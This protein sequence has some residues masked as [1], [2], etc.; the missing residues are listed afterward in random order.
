MD[1]DK[2]FLCEVRVE[3]LYTRRCFAVLNLVWNVFH[4]L[5]LSNERVIK[6][7]RRG[8]KKEKETENKENKL[9]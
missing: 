8:A 6:R 2:T 7:R 9:L 4:V 1:L 3:F 5:L